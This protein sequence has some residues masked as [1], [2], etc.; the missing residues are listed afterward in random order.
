LSGSPGT[1]YSVL[2]Q[3]V[4]LNEDYEIHE[5]IELSLGKFLND[6]FD[7]KLLR[8]SDI[9]FLIG[10]PNKNTDDAVL[11]EV[12]SLI[13]RENKPVFFAFGHTLDFNRLR[14]F[15]KILP[16]KFAFLSERFLETEVTANKTFNSL[17][18]NSNNTL[19]AWE[20]LPP[21]TIGDIRIE[22][23]AASE[24]LLVSKETKF[25]IVFTNSILETKSVIIT[26]INIW[27]WKLKA[28]EKDYQLFNNFV[29]NA[30][31]W[32]SLKSNDY[33]TVTLEDNNFSSGEIIKFNANLYNTT[34]EPLSNEK[35][36]LRISNS[37]SE[38]E[39]LFEPLGNG[40]YEADIRLKKPGL[41]NFSA[42]LEENIEN[43][44][45][46]K[47]TFNISPVEIEL[48]EN[49]LNR[50]QLESISSMT[51]GKYYN[52]NETNNLSNELNLNYKNKIYFDLID[53]E[54]RLSNIEII[55]LIIVLLFSI[56]WITRKVLRMI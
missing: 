11:D 46:V 31:K 34:F 7:T 45:S 20:N 22:P 56:E 12:I 4:S 47:G 51:G 26:A 13:Q 29:L 38:S 1:D 39:Y 21:V 2:K 30:I 10:F 25:P 3:T 28:P 36:T 35:I 48:I 23:N 42:S 6:N 32:L 54:L 18:S 8:E 40:I 19:Q 55:L 14:K 52:L 16:F 17:L 37:S 41:Y 27:K 5:I 53:K 9:I 44:P 24:I 49:K 33:F 15:E 43:L 50:D